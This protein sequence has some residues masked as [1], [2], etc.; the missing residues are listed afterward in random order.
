[1]QYF[2]HSSSYADILKY[3]LPIS[4]HTFRKKTVTQRKESH[5]EFKKTGSSSLLNSAVTL[6][7]L[8]N[9]LG[10]ISAQEI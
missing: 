2:P 4:L 10:P 9:L 1:M 6:G 7:K 3:Q 5:W 8:L